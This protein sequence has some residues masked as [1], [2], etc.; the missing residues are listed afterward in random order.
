MVTRPTE[1]S[2]HE[3]NPW[4]H[5]TSLIET[6]GRLLGLNEG[7]IKRIITPERIL[8]VAVPVRMDT[9]EV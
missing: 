3:F 8:E 2:P 6:A 4:L 9:G 5:V 1:V 7:L